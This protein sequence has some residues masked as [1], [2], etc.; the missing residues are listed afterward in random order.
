MMFFPWKRALRSK[1]FW[2]SLLIMLLLGSIA[3][4]APRIAPHDPFEGSFKQT[5]LPPMWVQGRTNSGTAEYPLGTDR[6][7]RD[8]L[9]RMLYGMRT[10]FFLALTAVPLAALVG[11]VIGLIAGNAGGK[12]DSWILLFMDM[13]SSLP[14]IMFV[15]IIV[16][17]FRSMLTPTWSHGLLTLV[18]GFAAIGWVSLARMIRVNVLQIKSQSFVEAAVALGASRRRIILQHLLPN[19]LHIIM[20]WIINNVP[21]VILLEAILGYI[22]VGVTSAVDGGEFSIIS[23]GGMFFSG[24]SA[25]T[26]NP[27]MLIIPSICILLISM[28][29]I[30]L[31]DFLAS[32]YRR[33]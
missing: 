10:A 29:F 3:A 11:T 4:L 28:S 31:A 20:I 1:T 15:V 30:L 13:I 33:E 27:L 24:R 7:G 17:I 32:V 25:L 26:S 12:L 18:V 9:S 21:A 6:Y 5:R 16:L 19:V 2:F 8:I 23:W 14:G 22:G